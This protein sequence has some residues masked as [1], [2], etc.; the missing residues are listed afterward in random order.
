MVCLFVC[1]FATDIAMHIWLDRFPHLG[2][3]WLINGGWFLCISKLNSLCQIQTNKFPFF[4]FFV[5]YWVNVLKLSSPNWWIVL[6]ICLSVY[7]GYILYIIFYIIW[8]IPSVPYCSVYCS[9]SYSEVHAPGDQETP[10]GQSQYCTG[11]VK[12]TN[13][14]FRCSHALLLRL[15]KPFYPVCL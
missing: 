15:K 5:K 4:F 11:V 6:S 7:V 9:F 1:L 14:C 2:H 13:R 8:R 3:T 12:V 10:A